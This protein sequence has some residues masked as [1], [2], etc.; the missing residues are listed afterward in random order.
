MEYIPF[1]RSTD[2]TTRP[3]NEVL[4]IVTASLSNI[5]ELTVSQQVTLHNAFELLRGANI[6]GTAGS[7]R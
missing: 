7:S 1:V 6:F 3:V 2:L 5:Y 4:L